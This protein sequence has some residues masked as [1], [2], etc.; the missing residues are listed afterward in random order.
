MIDPKELMIGN[1][2]KNPRYFKEWGQHL[3][4]TVECICGIDIS[5]NKEDWD[6]DYLEPVEL[7]P[8]ILEAAGFGY[9]GNDKCFGY[10]NETEGILI[11]LGDYYEDDG[12]AVFYYNLP[13][14]DN[15]TCIAY[16]KH[17]HQ[18]QNLY[19]TL[20]GQELQIDLQKLN[21]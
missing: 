19:F 18:L 5:T 16:C 1:I 11:E 3:Y 13:Y 4:Q 7:T 20:T 15:S 17:L 9:N 2:V 6:A 21:K 12:R 10:V 8:E 14:I